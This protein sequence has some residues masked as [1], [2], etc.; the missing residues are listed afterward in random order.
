MKLGG[1]LGNADSAGLIA[2]VFE[3]NIGAVFCAGVDVA[4]SELTEVP[5]PPAV[6]NNIVGAAELTA[7]AEVVSVVESAPAFSGSVVPLVLP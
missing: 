5:T 6:P 7:I 1:I 4:K 3:P 2:V